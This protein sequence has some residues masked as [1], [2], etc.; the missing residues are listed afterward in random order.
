L[1]AIGY[2]EAAEA[3]S[4]TMA[5]NSLKLISLRGLLEKQIPLAI[6]PQLTEGAIRVMALMDDLL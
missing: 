4:N 3:I 6:P 5:E 2:L 1:G